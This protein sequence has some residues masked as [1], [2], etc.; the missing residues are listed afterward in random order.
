LLSFLFDAPDALRLDGYLVGDGTESQ[1][2]P[3]SAVIF[4][5]LQK[6]IFAPVNYRIE[7]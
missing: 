2:T 3:G 6:D 7:L 5:F 4:H 1:D